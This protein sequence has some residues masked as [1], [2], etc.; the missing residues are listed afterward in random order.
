MTKAR[1]DRIA[2]VGAALLIVVFT[3]RG[4]DSLREKAST[5]DE[6]H[7][8]GIGVH[9]L[10]QRSWDI[11]GAILH[12]PLAYYLQGLPLLFF[13]R[14]ESLFEY[15]RGD[16]DE[17]SFLGKSEYRRGRRWLSSPANRDDRLLTAA[18]LPNLALG[19]VLGW[20]VFVWARALAGSAA[21]V[22]ATLLYTF[23]PNVLAHA[24]LATTDVPAAATLL[25]F[26]YVY[27]RTLRSPT[28]G[29][30]LASSV[31]LGLALL[32]RHTSALLLATAP[33]LFWL[34]RRSGAAPDAR[35]SHVAWI[36]AGGLAVFAI[37][38]L[39]DPHPYFQGIALQAARVSDGVPSFF[40]GEL[41]DGGWWYFQLASL[42]LKTPLPFLVAGVAG[43]AVLVARPE[44]RVG[45]AHLLAV[46][47]TLLALHTVV[48]QSLGVRYVW[49]LFPV[50]A[51]AAGALWQAA[52][53]G[54]RTALALVAAWQVGGS[55][56][57]HPH[58]LAHMNVLAGGPSNGHRYLVD[59]NF[60]WGQDLK[61]LARH[62]EERGIDRIALSYFGT[63]DPARYGID[64]EWLPS[65]H[66]PAEQRGEPNT[67]PPHG[68]VAISATN[69]RGV[70]LETHRDVYAELRERP[71]DSVVGHTIFL[72][73][74]E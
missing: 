9:L 8:L 45:A 19:A 24:R 70:Y 1:F 42:A 40:G 7:Y 59:S 34:D 61:G 21:G 44:Q 53:R 63:D 49:P 14:P 58:Y 73:E 17:L 50:L 71:A 13:D 31:L 52:G 39:G 38:Y 11:S 15:P 33:V 60:D 10:E 32:G 64:Y 12:P 51:I 6:T 3:L 22:V 41:R 18:R 57:L 46:P 47:V 26:S 43:C 30:L 68:W 54:R 29:W 48:P 72:Y 74:L 55:L 37:G 65:F 20:L 66:L 56:L 69:L 28:R 4:D 67:W 27:W 5:W 16:D 23:S 25:G 62:L 2:V 36:A 35:L